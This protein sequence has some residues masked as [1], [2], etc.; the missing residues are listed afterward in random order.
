MKGGEQQIR[1]SKPAATKG[2]I[3]HELCHALGLY[4]EMC[5]SDRDKYIKVNFDV[6]NDDERYQFKHTKNS[7]NQEQM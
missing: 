7:D 3:M 5:R 6:M 1:I 2:V 4:H